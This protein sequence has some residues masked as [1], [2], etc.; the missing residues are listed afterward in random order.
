M[1]AF[2]IAVIK[3]TITSTTNKHQQIITS[4]LDKS[5]LHKKTKKNFIMLL[6]NYTQNTIT[7]E[8]MDSFILLVVI[9]IIFNLY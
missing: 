3:W 2:G 1:A 9:G 5:L 8:S 6:I 4:N 7:W